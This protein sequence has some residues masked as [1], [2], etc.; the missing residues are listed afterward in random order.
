MSGYRN[1]AGQ[2]LL[3]GSTLGNYKQPGGSVVISC[4]PKLIDNIDILEVLCQVWAEDVLASLSANQ[5]KSFTHL[6][7]KVK[8]IIH[9]IYPVLFADEF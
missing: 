5:K 9:K 4:F 1:Y 3:K 2:T 7:A 8:E 6:I